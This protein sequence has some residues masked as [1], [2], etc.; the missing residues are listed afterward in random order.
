VQI[1][2]G[3]LVELVIRQSPQRVFL[4]DVGGEAK[5][6]GDVDHQSDNWSA[7]FA[8]AGITK[9]DTIVSFVPTCSTAVEVW[10]GIAKLGAVEVPLNT[11]LRG[12]LLEHQLLDSKAEV[13][14]V[15]VRFL[16]QILELANAVRQ[17][18]LIIVTGDSGVELAAGDALAPA[19][20]F[21]VSAHG[22]TWNRVIP[23]RTDTASVIYTSG[24]TGPSK[25]VIVSWAQIAATVQGSIPVADLESDDS[26]YNPF[27]LFHI[28]G[29]FPIALAALLGSR[30]VLRDGFSTR[31]FWSD[32]QRYGCNTTLLLGVTA[33]F[34]SQQPEQPLDAETPLRNVVMVP[35]IHDHE[36]FA[37]RFGVRICTAF[38][39]TEVSAPLSSEGWQPANNRTSGHPRAGYEC[40]VVDADDN[41]VPPNSPGELLVRASDR[42]TLNGGYWGRPEATASAWRGGW[43]HTGDIFCRDEQGEFYFLDRL[44][45]AIRRRGENISSQEIESVVVQHDAV[46][47]CAAH[48]VPSEW[49]ED[50]VKIVVVLHDEHDVSPQTLIDYLSDRLPDFM[51]PRYVEYLPALPKTPTEKIQKV[52]LRERG[53]TDTTWDRLQGITTELPAAK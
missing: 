48:A 22:T 23:S 53:I 3:S 21:L 4:H 31:E 19:A 7:A 9:D 37:R 13:A 45:D 50:E 15:D 14:V 36:T 28:G 46:A 40:R 20:D 47:E 49:G 11:H 18:R 32:V 39:M 1:A 52:S 42:A 26:Y 17:L 6:Y 29:K 38:N 30:V 5:T 2:D 24:T 25:G 44:K 34:L 10:L 43:F 12:Q 35:L 16:P 41:D 8:L 33:N 51:V 27:P